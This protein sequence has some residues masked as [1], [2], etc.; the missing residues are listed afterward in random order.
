MND[1][2]RG[3]SVQKVINTG[4]DEPSRVIKAHIAELDGRAEG[5]LSR[6]HRC[7]D[8]ILTDIFREPQPT[9]ARMQ[10]AFTYEGY[11]IYVDQ[12]GLATFVDLDAEE[13]VSVAS[14]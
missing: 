5:E 14:Y 11:R 9:D 4:I 13:S 7:V 2:G 10:V 3:T 1:S 12:L 6:V 8:D